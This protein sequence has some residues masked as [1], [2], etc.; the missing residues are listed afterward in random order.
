M[1]ETS[2]VTTAEDLLRLPD[3]G[4]RRE[5]V[6]G[7]LREMVPAGARHGSVVMALAAPLS[8]HARTSRLGI[9]LAAKTGFRLSRN[10]DTVRAPDVS[11]VARERV[12]V[13]GPPDG[14][15]DL[16]PD[17]AVEVVSPNDAAAEVQAKVQMWLEAGSRLVWVVY[18]AT[19]SVVVH[20]SLKDISTLTAADVLDGGEVVPG[21]ELCVAEAFE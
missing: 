11:F 20:R 7:E 6:R 4:K 10:P 14:Y 9:V 18:P 8:Q 12:P 1:A 5:L 19:R 16:A 15:W 3:D 21:F 17:L 2:T 13:G